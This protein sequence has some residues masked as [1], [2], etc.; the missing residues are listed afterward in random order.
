[1]MG[2][3]QIWR[4][5][6]KIPTRSCC[7]V[8]WLKA[9]KNGTPDEVPVFVAACVGHGF[10]AAN[11]FNPSGYHLL[12]RDVTKLFIEKGA[13]YGWVKSNM[14][15]TAVKMVMGKS[16]SLDAME[17]GNS[18]K[19]LVEEL[20]KEVGRAWPITWVAVADAKKWLCEIAIP[21]TGSDTMKSD[22][23]NFVLEWEL[24]DEAQGLDPHC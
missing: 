9:W 18:D 15:R 11:I 10:R 14:H 19:K 6:P 17:R 1:M 21:S 2:T 23:S 24:D 8:Q 20:V 22:W 7:V 16:P 3:L 4:R 13:V 5:H 12:W